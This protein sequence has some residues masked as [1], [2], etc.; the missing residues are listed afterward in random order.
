MRIYKIDSLHRHVILDKGG[1]RT[2]HPR[3]EHE[4]DLPNNNTYNEKGELIEERNLGRSDL[5]FS[6]K[7]SQIRPVERVEDF[8]NYQ[9]EHSENKL[10][11]IKHLNTGAIINSYRIAQKPARQKILI[12]W[13]AEKK[14]QLEQP[15]FKDF[16]E[17]F[18]H[19]YSV[20]LHFSKTVLTNS[21]A[22][23]NEKNLANLLFNMWLS[24]NFGY[25]AGVENY[26]E[27]LTIDNYKQ[28]LKTYIKEKKDKNSEWSRIVEE[29]EREIGLI[30]EMKKENEKIKWLG[31]PEQFGFIFGEL[32]AKGYIELPTK[33]TEGCFSKL[34]ELSLQYFEILSTK[35]KTKGKQTTKENLERAINP[36]T[37][38]LNI[39]A[40]RTLALPRIEDLK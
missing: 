2:S 28:F 25:E 34:A 13:L 18:N 16:E 22:R 37:N 35:G 20:G 8:L 10:Q 7:L 19:S 30:D 14:K 38:S 39:K 27:F 23:E 29:N 32:V 40:K 24:K 4:F 12:D 5:D 1:S 21:S 33:E 15:I 17:L 11:F 26:R 3:T 6:F 36:E 31:S 9:L